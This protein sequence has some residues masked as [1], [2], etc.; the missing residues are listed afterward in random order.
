MRLIRGCGLNSQ[1]ND[2]TKLQNTNMLIA[3]CHISI[4]LNVHNN[5]DEVD[6]IIIIMQ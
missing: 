5:K 4:W 1:I 6:P 3:K 2:G